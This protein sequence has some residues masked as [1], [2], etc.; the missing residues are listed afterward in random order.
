MLG[1][2]SNNP[3][4]DYG[5]LKCLYMFSFIVNLYQILPPRRVKDRYLN[6]LHMRK[7]EMNS[8]PNSSRLRRKQ[9]LIFR[10]E[11]SVKLLI[12]NGF[13]ASNKDGDIASTHRISTSS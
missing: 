5:E 7:P 9:Y 10:F 11:K 12:R 13:H 8:H 6:K 2:K 3:V 1:K 4:A